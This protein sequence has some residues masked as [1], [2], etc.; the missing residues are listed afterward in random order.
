MRKNRVILIA[1]TT[2]MV[3]LGTVVFAP[4]IVSSWLRIWLHWQARRQ[5]LKIEY[6][7]IS[8]P[9]LRPIS[10]DHIRVT[11]EPGAATQMELNADQTTLYLSLIK[12]VAGR[13]EGVRS[14]SIKSAHSEIRRDYSG[15]PRSAPFDWGALQSLLP[16]NFDIDHLD[17]R[18]EN[19]PTV[20][21]LLNAS[22]SGS[23][24]EAG[25]FTAG[26]FTIVSP[27]L[28]QK[29]SQMRGAT[30][31]RDDRLTIGGMNL[32]NGLDLQS[33]NID[34]SRL[35]S[36]RANLQFDLDVLGGKIRGSIS[37]EWPGQHS[38]WNVAGTA[39]GISLAQTSEAF[40]FTDRL[41]GSLRACNFTFRGD[42]RDPM[43]GT[44]SVWTELNGLSWYNRAADLIML[45]AIFYNRQIQLQQLYIKQRQN[46]LSMSGEG[47]IPSKSSDWLNPD[48]RG[49]ILGKIN[50]LGQ[51][52]EL[53]GAAPKT[54][55]GAI[56]IEGTLNAGQKKLGGFLTA[57]GNSLSLFR[58]QIDKFSAKLNLKSDALELEQFEVLRKKDFFRAQ[59]RIDIAHENDYSGS[60]EAKVSDASDYLLLG[61]TG[62]NAAA[63]PVQLTAKISSGSW[64]SQGSFTLPGSNPVDMQARFSLK[65][66]QD[67]KTFLASP[68]AATIRFPAVVFAGVPQILHPSVFSE[69]ILSG[70]ISI[71]QSLQHPSINGEIQLLN[72]VLQNAPLELNRAS[73]QLTFNGEH[74]TLEFLN[75][76]TKEV[77][78]SLKGEV[79]L[80]NSNDAIVR[81]SSTEPVFDTT[82]SV[83]NCIRGVQ[84]SP[85]DVTLAPTV[86][87]LELR[88]DLFGESWK[89]GLKELGTSPAAMI[90]NPLSREFHFCS[91][92][93]AEGEIFTFGI[94]PRPQPTPAKPRRRGRTR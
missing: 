6:G 83:Q 94:H 66:G 37:N 3:A 13:S 60:I 49:Q 16:A 61:K 79:D 39:T 33:I 82:V 11:S 20:V 51:F 80:R 17:L 31:W 78:L 64:D 32:A 19:G 85:V 90:A 65:L 40:G 91:G 52:A 44:A 72:G 1:L 42:P 89:M 59:G 9:F 30:K 86:Q 87:E 29:F 4:L 41:G 27:M 15:N 48:F 46:E 76:A 24:I 69:G 36:K 23:Q 21:L 26:E 38:I 84:I 63:I 77:D 34:L 57:T 10:I 35:N 5:H 25:R 22:I 93:T 58:R 2:V 47:A 81:I 68:V 75:A 73:G 70:T 53:F 67:W 56:G 8:A 14:L 28:R 71:T 7:K 45:G 12:V 54:F 74:G 43:S 92:D 50:D 62:A 18:V 88:G 55:A